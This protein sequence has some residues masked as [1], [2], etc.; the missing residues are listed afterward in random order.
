MKKDEINKN[1]INQQSHVCGE[2]A[3]AELQCPPIIRCKIKN[4]FMYLETPACEN[5]KMYKEE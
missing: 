1:S 2:C 3:Y 4:K 5:F